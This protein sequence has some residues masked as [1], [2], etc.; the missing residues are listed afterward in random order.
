MTSK[1]RRRKVSA[2]NRLEAQLKTGSKPEKVD[3]RTTTNNI[4]LSESDKNRMKKELETLQKSV[5]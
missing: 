5:M 1:Q 2:F 3:G 4:Q